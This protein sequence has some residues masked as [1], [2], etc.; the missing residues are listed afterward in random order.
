M[1]FNKNQWPST[2]NH[3]YWIFAINS[4]HETD[5]QI[6]HIEIVQPQTR[7]VRK[8]KDYKSNPRSA[9]RVQAQAVVYFQSSR[10]LLVCTLQWSVHWILEKKRSRRPLQPANQRLS[11]SQDKKKTSETRS[12]S[13]CLNRFLLIF[14]AAKGAKSLN[15]QDQ[16]QVGLGFRFSGHHQM[17]MFMQLTVRFYC[18]FNL[19][20]Q[21]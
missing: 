7:T 13:L 20:S 5:R 19:V 14:R 2:F 10:L 18:I 17:Q 1:L 11:A 21:Q 4:N 8:T 12:A 15:L 3:I 9:C 6:I 16:I